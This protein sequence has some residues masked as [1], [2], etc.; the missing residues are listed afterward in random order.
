MPLRPPANRPV[1]AG[2]GVPIKRVLRRGTLFTCGVCRKD[3]AR[4]AQAEA[5]LASCLDKWLASNAGA[6]ADAPTAGEAKRF[7][8][9]ICRRVYEV[10]TEAQACSNAC[11]AKTMQ[12]VEEEREVFGV[13]APVATGAE[14]SRPIARTPH[15]DPK[16]KTAVR[17]DQMHKF[18]RDG[19]KLVCRKCGKE[20]PSLDE[21]IACYDADVLRLEAGKNATKPAAGAS[22]PHSIKAA[23]PSSKEA[24]PTEQSDDHKFVRDNAKYKCRNCGAKYFTKS[25]VVAC[26]DKH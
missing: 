3:H 2:P 1:K 15:S 23:V 20:F 26:F 14:P 5:C 21:V 9:G 12:A 25:D 6:A 16:P 10:R 8:C 11:R 7:R 13:R 4:E 18:L 22:A 17:R 19:R 24:P